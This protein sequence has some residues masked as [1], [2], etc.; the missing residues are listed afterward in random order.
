MFVRFREALSKTPQWPLNL[1][2]GAQKRGPGTQSDTWKAETD[3]KRFPKG[4]GFVL[5]A[6]PI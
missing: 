4:P 6:H 2:G 3:A 1:P 5:A